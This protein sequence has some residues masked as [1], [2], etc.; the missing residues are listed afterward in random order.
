MRVVIQN[1]DNVRELFE[2][3]VAAVGAGKARRAFSIALN[4]IGRDTNVKIKR[5]LV[6]QTS[7]R[8]R[9]VDSSVRPFNSTPSTLRYVIHGTGGP[10]GLAYF[11]PKQKKVGVA[12]KVWGDSEL[13][14]HT[15]IVGA[16]GGNVYKRLK[17]D[18]GPLKQL[19]GPG[20]ARELMRDESIDAFDQALPKLK[21]DVDKIMALLT[22]GVIK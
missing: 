4:R 22:S 12:V 15:F 5:A 8:K 7:I 10:K 6:T 18:R 16:Y 21:A 2:K 1:A 17:H 9:D 13:Y 3:A 19:Y 14:E 11:R 20:I